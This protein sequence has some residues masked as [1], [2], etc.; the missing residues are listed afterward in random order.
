MQLSL[1]VSSWQRRLRVL[2][3][4]FI[5]LAAADLTDFEIKSW[6]QPPLSPPA[7]ANAPPM[8]SGTLDKEGLSAVLSTTQPTDAE[9]KQKAAPPDGPGANVTPV[10]AVPAGPPPRLVGTIAGSGRHLAVLEVGNETTVAGPGK[11][12][13]GYRILQVDT[14]SARVRDA[15]GQVQLLA[16]EIAGGTPTAQPPAAPTPAAAEAAPATPQAGGPVSI[17]HAQYKHLVDNPDLWISQVQ[18]KMDRKGD[19]VLGARVSYSGQENPF[20]LVG[21]QTGDVISTF[22]QRPLK[23][24]DD[25]MWARQEL[26]NARLFHFDILRN[27]SP[28]TLDVEIKD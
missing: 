20:A 24:P 7:P 16:L 12:V 10:P 19:E 23:T 3:V 21:I 15:A 17:P 28:T 13:S 1:S 14:Y 2:L 18:L 5:A 26:A 8:T 6:L 11:L 25:L 9:K 22:N 27:G 4:V